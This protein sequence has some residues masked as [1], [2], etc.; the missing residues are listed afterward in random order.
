[1]MAPTSQTA[2][3]C[4]VAM[5][6]APEEPLELRDV[7]LP[8]PMSGGALVRIDCCTL[9]GS[10]LHT[11]TGHRKEPAPSVLGHEAVGTV[12]ELGTP[13]LSDIAGQPLLPGDRITWSPVVSCGTCPRCRAGMLQKCLSLFKYGHALA[14]GPGTL[15]GGL[16]EFIHL[17]PGTAAVQLPPEVPDEVFSPA[18]CATATIAAA[19]RAAGSVAGRRVLILGA[20]MLGLTATAFAKS[21]EAS[22]VVISDLNRERL[23]RAEEFGADA[24]VLWQNERESFRQQLRETSG[25]DL[26]DVL[27]DVSGAPDA[28]E[29]ACQLGDVGAS[30]VLVGSV[31]PT[32][33]VPID[34]ESIVRRLLTI[35]GVHNY[36]PQDLHTA[37]EFLTRSHSR[38][39]F[40][41]L[42][43]QTFPLERVNEAVELALRSRPVRLAVRPGK[44]NR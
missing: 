4:R 16:A 20:G 11:I 3:T 26:F 6:V 19:F 34:P 8:S 9:C 28:I 23:A 43:E 5:F 31:S 38:F 44:E 42:V 2:E 32:R 30:I 37:V 10:D 1:M 18:S 24:T 14:D 35:R 40:I 36:A 27:L 21:N 12:V 17:R 13:A 22:Q 41:Q 15:S 33:P 25:G 39:P 29:A 7:P